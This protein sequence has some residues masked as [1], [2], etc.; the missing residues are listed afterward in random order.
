M[1]ITRAALEKAVKST[2]GPPPPPWAHRSASVSLL[3]FGDHETRF[4]AI[5]KADRQGYVWRNQIAL[6]GGLVE[7]D[8][9]DSLHAAKRELHEELNIIPENVDYIGSL[10]HFQT[11]QNTVIEVFVGFWNQRDTIYFDT[12]EIAKVLKVPLEAVVST[13]RQ[14]HL[15]GRLPPMEELLYPVENLVIWGVTAKILHHFIERLYPD[16][17]TVRP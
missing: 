12:R 11:L 5:L 6:P 10:G 7:Q 9:P 1:K 15:T 2:A 14:K 3:L 17:N 8:D 13:H 16:V 4:L